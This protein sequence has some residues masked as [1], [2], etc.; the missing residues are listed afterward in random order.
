MIQLN[1]GVVRTEVQYLERK[2]SNIVDKAMLMISLNHSV[3][4]KL[5]LQ[6]LFKMGPISIINLW[7]QQ[8]LKSLIQSISIVDP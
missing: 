5:R 2:I 3:T 4:R 1:V 8:R 6:L 7:K